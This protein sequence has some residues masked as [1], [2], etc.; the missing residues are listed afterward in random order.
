MLAEFLATWLTTRSLVTNFL[1]ATNAIFPITV[2]KAKAGTTGYYIVIGGP[3]N[4]DDGQVARNLTTKITETTIYI[5]GP[6]LITC[7]KLASAIEEEL[8]SFFRNPPCSFTVPASGPNPERHLWISFGT[9]V[10]EYEV[11]STNLQG[12]QSPG[13]CIVQVWNI[14]HARTASS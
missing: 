13:N 10:D 7:S 8:I 14:P 4:T 9:K 5:C 12:A 2:S 11:S 1:S 6:S 3:T